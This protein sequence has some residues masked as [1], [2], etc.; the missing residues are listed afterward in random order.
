[1]SSTGPINGQIASGAPV[2]TGLSP[3]TAPLLPDQGVLT[4]MANFPAQTYKLTLGSSIVKLMS[5]M[6]GPSGGGQLRQRSLVNRLRSSVSSTYY[7]DLDNSLGAVLGISRQLG[8]SL[9]FNPYTT[10]APSTGPLSWLAMAEADATYRDRLFQVLRAVSTYGPTALGIQ[11]IAESFLLAPVEVQE[12]YRGHSTSSITANPSLAYYIT[13]TPHVNPTPQQRYGLMKILNK[14][15]PALSTIT[16]APAPAVDPYLQVPIGGAWA[17]S[18]YWEVQSI[19]S[20]PS[21]YGSV[22]VP[23]Y[24]FGSSQAA[25]WTVN[26]WVS[27]VLSYSQNTDGTLNTPTDFE[28]VTWADGTITNYMPIYAMAPA[29]EAVLGTMVVPGNASANPINSDNS[30][31][32]DLLL[33][34]ASVQS[35]QAASTITAQTVPQFWSTPE[36][37][38]TDMTQDIIEIRFS[39]PVNVNAISF[40]VANFPCT[41]TFQVYDDTDQTWVGYYS[42]TVTTSVPAVLPNPTD[43][44]VAKTHPQHFGAGHWVS[45][46]FRFAPTSIARARIVLVRPGITG[47]QGPISAMTNNPADYSLGVTEFSFDY[48]VDS[49]DQLP[50]NGTVSLETIGTSTDVAGNTITYSVYS[51]VPTATDGSL[52]QWRCFPQP[53][54]NAVVNLYLDTRDAEGNPQVID[55]FFIT[56]THLGVGCTLYFAL[57][58][59]GT[60]GDMSSLNWILVNRSYILMTGWMTV[61]P[62]AARYWKFEMSGLVAEPLSNPFPVTADILMFGSNAVNPTTG[63]A[64]YQGA[65]PAGTT[66]NAILAA[67]NSL[68]STP[69]VNPPNSGAYSPATALVANDPTLAQ[70]LQNNFANYG[71]IDWQPFGAPPATLGGLEDYTTTT[72]ASVNSV[73]F[74]TGFSSI[75]AYRTNPACPIDSPLYYELFYDTTQIASANGQTI[76]GIYSGPGTAMATN[77]NPQ[78]ELLE[79]PMVVTSKAYVSASMVQKVQFATQQSPPAEVVPFDTFRN[80]RYLP[81]TTGGY[82]WDDPQDWNNLGMGDSTVTFNAQTLTPIITRGATSYT[83]PQANGLVSG[84]FLTSPVGWVTFAV[85]LSILSVPPSDP[86][87]FAEHPIYLQLCEWN[88]GGAAPTVLVEW[89]L[90]AVAVGQ[91]IEEYFSY[92]VGST[93]SP[94]TFLC[95]AVAQH[96]GANVASGQ[97]ASWVIQAAS[98]FDPSM[99]WS[100]SSDG[101]N[102]VEAGSVNFVHNNRNGVVSIPTPSTHLYWQVTIYRPDMFVNVLKIRP[103]YQMT[104]RPRVA[105]VASGPNMSFSDTDQTIWTDPFFSTT[106]GPVP[107]WWFAKYQQAALFPDG[108]PIITPG[109]KIYAQDV[110]ETV[111]PAHDTAV[112]TYYMQMYHLVANTTTASDVATARATLHTTTRDTVGPATDTAS[113]AIT[114]LTPYTDV[115]N[116]TG[117]AQTWTCPQNIQAGVVTIT[118][119]GGGG[120]GAAGGLGGQVNFTLPVVPGQTLNIIVGGQGSYYSYNAEGGYAYGYHTGG[121]M[122]MMYQN[123][124]TYGQVGNYGTLGFGGSSSAVTNSS[125]VLIAE[126]GAGGGQGWLFAVTEAVVNQTFNYVGG[127]QTWTLPA[128]SSGQVTVTATGGGGGS[129][130][131]SSGPGTPPSLGGVGGVVQAVFNTNAGDTLTVYVGGQGA[132]GG[133]APGAN[134]FAPFGYHEG[135]YANYGGA[136]GGSSSAVLLNGTLMMEAGAGGGSAGGGVANFYF[137]GGAGGNPN[138]GNAPSSPSWGAWGGGG[139]TQT[140]GG[141][142]VSGNTPGTVG[143]P[144]GSINGGNANY[145]ASGQQ[146]Y[147]GPCGGG[148][149]G[150]AGGGAGTPYASAAAYFGGGGGSSWAGNGA[151]GIAYGTAGSIS[152]GNVVVSYISMNIGAPTYNQAWSGG[153]G[154]N[155]NGQTAAEVAFGSAYSYGGAG[156]TQSAGGAGGAWASTQPSGNTSGTAPAGSV[157][158]VGGGGINGGQAYP[159]AGGGGGGGG[160]AGGG[161]GAYSIYHAAGAWNTNEWSG[162]GGGSSWAG[163]GATN[164]SYGT[165]ASLGNGN[166]WVSYNTS[167]ARHY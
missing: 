128:I 88:G 131:T 48:V 7:T 49:A 94:E 159:Y 66:T 91:T 51:E 57:E 68:L 143:G 145:V 12:Y 108:V 56:P 27:G 115:F 52:D 36:R 166:V 70:A 87:F 75:T 152:A 144:A 41:A 80:G 3:V 54:N 8:E 32:S 16:L 20:A 121:A 14:I 76:G 160:Y 135:G 151:A 59:P 111:G 73:G 11:L 84:P 153:N 30:T 167:G 127:V 61:Y 105:A 129:Q 157:G 110:V 149:G 155:P 38:Y 10:A 53:V 134:N 19:S 100:F 74:F 162:G 29:S 126:A 5:T 139:A 46:A 64:G 113:G 22:A 55:R 118:I 44:L 93:V 26:G 65:T 154:G 138:G 77:N 101:V 112:V 98:G 148:G 103:W 124:L 9:P 161:A 90:T 42:Q 104:D 86:E 71:Y 47:P 96:S 63:S 147:Y 40:Q 33:S 2:P 141:S 83:G 158:A 146:A 6:V 67:G 4:Q 37:A 116:Y 23:Q 39:S 24:A 99:M 132:G 35:I 69:T 92:Q 97:T 106:G 58:E 165:A 18:F 109:S 137:G 119:N 43:A 28:Q 62:V 15:K 164:I 78:S 85:R 156:A 150:F 133:S 95:L 114:T 17:S 25:A 130:Q 45:V 123:P 125:G 140:A 72:L 107:L 163:N 82:N 102:W 60:P 31:V 142:A 122:Y 89:P 81:Q 21:I 120:G 136:S 34:G 13:V 79:T 1:M 117:G 50:D